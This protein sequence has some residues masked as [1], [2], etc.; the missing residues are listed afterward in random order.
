MLTC[1]QVINKTIITS[2]GRILGKLSSAI[3]DDEW[4]IPYFSVLLERNLAPTFN[5][6]KPLFGSPRAF[7]EPK[8]V[9]AMSD[10]VILKRRLEEMSGY[11]ME[12]GLGVEAATVLG[13][14]VVGEGGYYFGDLQD[15]VMDQARWRIPELVV[16]V[17]KKAADDMG[18]PMT[19]FGTCQAKVPVKRV[20]ALRESVHLTIERD[21]FSQYVVKERGRA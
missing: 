1:R 2:D 15:M 20:E 5:I 4:R 12:K 8:E 14:K 10:N 17:R 6:R 13:R 16:E 7:L 3:V 18:F 19:L 11:L 9:A 21:E